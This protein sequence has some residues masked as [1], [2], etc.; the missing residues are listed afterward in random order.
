M[1]LFPDGSPTA[2]LGEL[3]LLSTGSNAGTDTVDAADEEDETRVP[4]PVLPWV[5]YNI[6]RGWQSVVNALV[7]MPAG[8]P[9]IRATRTAWNAVIATAFT[10]RG[11]AGYS[12]TSTRT[13][14]PHSTSASIPM[15]WPATQNHL[16]QPSTTGKLC[17]LFL[18][19]C[20]TSHIPIM[21]AS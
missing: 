19:S 6:V 12:F 11:N 17:M 18:T 10:V 3:S 14:L 1:N 9:T 21:C 13:T 8:M 20:A 5:E 4:R 7:G 15:H 16:T 2:L